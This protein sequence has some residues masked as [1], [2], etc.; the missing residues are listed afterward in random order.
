MIDSSFKNPAFNGAYFVFCIEKAILV[1]VV[2]RK[3][4][5][6]LARNRFDRFRTKTGDIFNLNKAARNSGFDYSG[7]NLK[8]QNLNLTDLC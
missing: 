6:I 3:V 7:K 8:Q 2:E 4:R 1:L 5:K